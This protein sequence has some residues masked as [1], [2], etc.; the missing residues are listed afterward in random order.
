MCASL[1]CSLAAASA[2][3]APLTDGDTNLMRPAPHTLP[4]SHVQMYTLPV[5][6][7]AHVRREDNSRGA[8]LCALVNRQPATA[9]HTFLSTDQRLPAPSPLPATL[10]A[11]N[12][13][14]GCRLGALRQP[15]TAARS[16]GQLG[17]VQRLAV[18]L[19]IHHQYSQCYQVKPR[20][21]TL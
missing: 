11:R 13:R 7:A 16:W 1:A 20:A 10:I 2:V 21:A 14:F 3:G 15:H 19:K 17:W 9:T 6:L 12:I 18:A 5:S 8:G 4:P